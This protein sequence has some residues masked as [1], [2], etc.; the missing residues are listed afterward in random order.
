MSDSEAQS[1]LLLQ[2]GPSQDEIEARRFN[3]LHNMQWK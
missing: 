1:D 2:V 3:G